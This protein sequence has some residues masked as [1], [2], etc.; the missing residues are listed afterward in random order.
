MSFRTTV[1]G[2]CCSEKQFGKLFFLINFFIHIIA[3]FIFFLC[4]KLSFR[5][6]FFFANCHCGLFLAN[7]AKTIQNNNLHIKKNTGQQIAKKSCCSTTTWNNRSTFCTLQK[8]LSMRTWFA[9]T[10]LKQQFAK[11]F[12]P[13]PKRVWDYITNPIK[14][15]PSI[16]IS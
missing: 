2:G 6:I 15:V 14:K 16:R 13:L 9:K 12:W 5:T 1:L 4:C 10:G 3:P 8:K 7:F 11:I